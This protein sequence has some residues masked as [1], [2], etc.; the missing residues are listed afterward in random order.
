MATQFTEENV[1]ELKF[2]LEDATI[3]CSERCLYQSA[4]WYD[5]RAFT[6]VI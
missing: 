3:K 6:P 5:A 2:R 4:K 1:Q